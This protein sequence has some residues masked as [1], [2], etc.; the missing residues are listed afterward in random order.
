MEDPSDS[1]TYS[2]FV[3]LVT[4]NGMSWTANQKYKTFCALHE[5]LINQYPSVTFPSTSYQFAKHT[6]IQSQSSQDRQQAL[7]TYL[8]E[9]A[10]IPVIKESHQ[11]KLFLGIN[12]R[13]PEL[14]EVKSFKILDEI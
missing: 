12:K 11:F 2:E 8:Q 3:I 10:L 13:C 1:K 6:S 9:L 7:Q 5:S 14:C 4:F